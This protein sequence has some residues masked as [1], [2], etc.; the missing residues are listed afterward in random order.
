MS[1]NSGY[2]S[3]I[4]KTRFAE[5]ELAT[6][7]GMFTQQARVK[8][9]TRGDYMKVQE[10]KPRYFLSRCRAKKR[11]DWRKN[12]ARF[13]HPV[14]IAKSTKNRSTHQFRR[15]VDSGSIQCGLN[16][17]DRRSIVDRSNPPSNLVD[18]WSIID[19][20]SIIEVD[21]WILAE[22]AGSL[23]HPHEF[24]HVKNTNCHSQEHDY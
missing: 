2:Y 23:H 21:W 20:W 7:R 11:G 6:F 18:P 16:L 24:I 1:K 4:G 9:Q 14:W 13:P 8:T 19:D 15:L 3:D 22:T 12:A 17:V 5:V 10:I